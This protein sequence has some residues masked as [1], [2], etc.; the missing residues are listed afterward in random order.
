MKATIQY[1]N[2][3]LA[4][5]YPVSEIESFTGI[6]FEAV[7]GFG[8]TE[9]I[10]RKH[11]KISKPDFEKIKTIIWRLKNLEPIQYILGETEFYGLKL[12]VNPSVLIPRPETEELVQWVLKSNLSE[13]SK[14][15]DIG[16]GSGCIA[17]AIKSRVK[18]AEVFGI[19]ISNTALVVARQNAIKNNLDVDFFQADIF[20][21]KHYNW[22]TYDVIVSNPP[23]IRENEK[24]L[25]HSNVLNYEPEK[26]LFVPDSEPL[27][28]YRAIG[29]FAKKYLSVN[30][31]LFLEINENLGLEMKEMLIDGG[32]SGIEIR[33]DINGK[34]RMVCCRNI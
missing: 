25:M 29:A 26:A 22:Q 15:L 20:K 11:E 7:C 2:S 17:L 16:T 18:S 14:I 30:G 21:W 10:I 9:Q 4:G 19:D 32:F 23:Y 1:I 28:F 8:F 24:L 31:M 33:K 3:E 5:F 13:N 12:A 27:V 6:I 34:N